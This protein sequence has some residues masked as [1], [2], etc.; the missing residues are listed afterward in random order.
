MHGFVTSVIMKLC[1]ADPGHSN[2]C[3]RVDL[4]QTLFQ[5]RKRLM[6]FRS[7]SFRKTNQIVS[8]TILFSSDSSRTVYR[9]QQLDSGMS[10]EFRLLIRRSPWRSIVAAGL[11]ALIAWNPVFAQVYNNPHAGGQNPVKAQA[12]YQRA[13]QAFRN[14]DDNACIQLCQAGLNFNHADKNLIHLMALA[15]ARAGDNYNAMMQFRAALSLDYNF[16][17]CRNNFGVFMMKTGKI[18]EAKKEF[19]ECIK[20]NPNYAEPHYH[21]GEILKQQGDLEA[22]IEEFRTAVTLKP[23]YP[24]ANRDLGLAIYEQY[25]QGK[26]KDISE[27]LDKLQEA[28]KLIPQDPMVHYYMGT[29]WCSKGNL[30]EAEK[31]FRISL[32]NDSNFAIGHFELGKLR[33]LRGDPDRCLVEMD[34]ALKVSP[35]YTDSKKYPKVNRKLIKQYSAKSY[36]LKGYLVYAIKDWNEVAAQTRDSEEILKHVKDLIRT[37][38]RLERAR[39]KGKGET[40]DREEVQALLIRGI[41]E[42][43]SGNLQAA[44]RT[45]NRT[46]ELHPESFE[47]LQNLGAIYEQEGAIPKALDHYRKALAVQP[48]YDG[49]YYNMGFVLEKMRLPVEAGGMYK[50]YHDLAGRYPYDPKHV[51]ELQ[52]MEVRQQRTDSYKRGF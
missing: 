49:A 45:Y 6:R 2:Q 17:E 42:V 46:L 52:L 21:R 3:N 40:Y 22:A 10:S 19:E 4:F 27:S 51:I 14:G 20:I 24:E 35:T 8:S 23:K 43:D 13:M 30:D 12:M 32:M 44:K 34:A 5:K 36:E 48:G 9:R 41:E 18:K 1:R 28:A 38:K 29:I 47:A 26:L 7:D 11:L 50:K 31:E 16:L 37:Q 15:Y 33:Y 39:S 25:S